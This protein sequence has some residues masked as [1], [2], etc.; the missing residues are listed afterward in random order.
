MAIYLGITSTARI[1]LAGTVGSGRS[2][3]GTTV[4]EA[5]GSIEIY[6]KPN[7]RR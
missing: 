7:Q 1:P 5:D 3:Q 6:D 4:R 2:R